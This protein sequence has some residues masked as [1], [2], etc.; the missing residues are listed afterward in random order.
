MSCFYRFLIDL[1]SILRGLGGGFGTFSGAFGLPGALKNDVVTMSQGQQRPRWSREAIW[2]TIL[3]PLEPPRRLPRRSKMRSRR[4]KSL[5]RG[6]KGREKGFQEASKRRPRRPQ[7]L[8]KVRKWDNTRKT[9]SERSER[10]EAKSLTHI[11]RCRVSVTYSDTCS[12][13]PRSER[14]SRIQRNL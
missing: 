11:V 14:P 2:G 7:T 1:G 10:S 4:S 12:E 9:R 3:G 6:S 5:P 8:P 13:A